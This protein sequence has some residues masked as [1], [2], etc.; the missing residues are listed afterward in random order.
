MLKTDRGEYGFVDADGQR[1]RLSIGFLG[2]GGSLVVDVKEAH[3]QQPFPGRLQ[4]RLPLDH[5]ELP[6]VWPQS[7]VG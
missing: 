2:V 4:P 7:R 3:P 6:V 1:I 5:R